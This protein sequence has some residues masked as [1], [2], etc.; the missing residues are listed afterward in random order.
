MQETKYKKLLNQKNI[1]P[2]TCLTAYSM[3]IA[4][5]ID[6]I[7]DII[8]VGDSLGNTLYGMK[9]TQTVTIDIMKNHGKAVTKHVNKS[10]T[11]ID[12]P[13]KSYESK[14]QALKNAKSI[15]KYTKY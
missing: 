12:L 8:L 5:I 2:I 6:G 7:V 9:N 14:K 1:K 4:K 11:I 10:L 15:L 13:Y 3:P